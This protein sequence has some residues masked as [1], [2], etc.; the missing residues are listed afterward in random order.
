MTQILTELEQTWKQQFQLTIISTFVFF[1]KIPTNIFYLS[2]PSG[3]DF[4]RCHQV[5]GASWSCQLLRKYPAYRGEGR[6][7]NVIRTGCRWMPNP[8]VSLNVK[9]YC[10]T[11]CQIAS[12]TTWYHKTG[13]GVIVIYVM[14]AWIKSGNIKI[15]S[16]QNRWIQNPIHVKI[17]L[18]WFCFAR[19]FTITILHG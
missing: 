12:D 19:Q 10:V 3:M 7:K 15:H 18:G 1:W 6:A 14:Q 8:T 4:P 2:S 9:S 13:L 17:V 16:P 5:L 11:E